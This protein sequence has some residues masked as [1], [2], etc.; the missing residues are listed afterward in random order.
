MPVTMT[1]NLFSEKKPTHGQSVI[2]LQIT[3]SFDAWGFRPREL[4]V[5]YQWSELD[6]D[7]YDTGNGAWYEE[8]D[9][10]LKGHRLVILADGWEMSETDLWM[11][12]E[13][14]ET[15]LEDNIPQLKE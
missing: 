7:G 5:E 1:W 4:T 11:S 10:P 2:W 14:Y 12:I 13:E 3:S 6:E 9:E 8:G 15:F